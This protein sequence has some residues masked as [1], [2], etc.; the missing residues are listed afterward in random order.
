LYLTDV[1]MIINLSYSSIKF[2]ALFV[3]NKAGMRT[4]LKINHIDNRSR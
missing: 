4:Q 2:P 1:G 3:V